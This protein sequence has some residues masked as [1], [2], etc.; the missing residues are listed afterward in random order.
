MIWGSFTSTRCFHNKAIILGKLILL[1]KICVWIVRLLYKSW[2][3][4][5]R[6][7]FMT[8]LVIKIWSLAKHK[9]CW[10]TKTSANNCYMRQHFRIRRYVRNDYIIRIPE[11]ATAFYRLFKSSRQEMICKK[12]FLKFTALESLFNKAGD[13]MRPSTLLKRGSGT[14]VFLK[15]RNL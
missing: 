12:M 15:T 13:L 9:S 10:L 2:K 8:L 6:L 14:G 3:N 7:A 4:K 5:I 1:V 11:M